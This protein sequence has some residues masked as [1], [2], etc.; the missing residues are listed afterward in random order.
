MH[1]YISILIFVL[2]VVIGLITSVYLISALLY[3]TG[4]KQVKRSKKTKPPSKPKKRETTKAKSDDSDTKEETVVV[5]PLPKSQEKSSSGKSSLRKRL[6]KKNDASWTD[7][8][9]SL[10][11]KDSN[12]HIAASRKKEDGAY[13]YIKRKAGGM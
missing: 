11:E 7:F 2:S 13:H 1:D 3:K 8:N 5:K 12:Q 9:C 4:K 6:D 10:N